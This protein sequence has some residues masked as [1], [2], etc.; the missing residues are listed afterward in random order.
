MRARLTPLHPVILP[1]WL[2]AAMP[3]WLKPWL[4]DRVCQAIDAV[5]WWRGQRDSLT[6]PARLRVR[7][8]CFASYIQRARYQAVGREFAD[9]LRRL[10]DLN[11]RTCML[12][13]GCGCGQIA[14]ALADSIQADGRY[15]GFD[16]DHA[17]ISWCQSTISARLPHFRFASADLANSL[18]NPNGR[19]RAEQFR[20][21]YADE[22]FDLILLKSIFTHMPGMQMQHYLHE[23]RRML[24]PQGV[25]LLTLYLLNDDSHAHIRAGHS[26]YAF[27]TPGEGCWVVDAGTPDYAVAHDEA[28]LRR[29]AADAGLC[30]SAPIQF[31]AWCGR[32]DYL[33]FQDLVLLRVADTV[34]D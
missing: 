10:C 25:C 6:P 19:Q 22:S 5:D 15:D 8:G 33:S 26:S 17:A 34:R 18:Y 24:R 11:A 2:R 30:V 13:I 1:Q 27:A 14:A 20:F 12:D 23:I 28:A 7:V 31:G 4:R 16:P 9:H 21:P 3:T 29:R 32:S